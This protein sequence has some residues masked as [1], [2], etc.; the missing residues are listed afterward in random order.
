MIYNLFDKNL[1][2]WRT[3]LQIPSIR[4]I[5][6]VITRIIEGCAH[7]LQ[8]WYRLDRMKGYLDRWAS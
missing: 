7:R 5:Y 3:F 8:V 2:E 4:L 6:S 1:I